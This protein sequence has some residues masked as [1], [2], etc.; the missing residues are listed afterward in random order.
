MSL[1]DW[2]RSASS[3]SRP[4]APVAV[5]YYPAVTQPPTLI[6]RSLPAPGVA[7]AYAAAQPSRLTGGWNTPTSSADT[8]I[9]SGL[10]NLRARSRALVRDSAYAK[11]AQIIVVNNVIGSGMGLQAQ[12]QSSR[13]NLLDRAN[14]GIET[15]WDRWTCAEY[16]HTGGALHFSDFERALIG[17]VFEAGEVFVRMHM[18]SFG[19]SDIPFALELIESERVPH[20]FQ[21]VAVT[22]GEARLG[23]EVDKYYRPI[24]YW[25]R[26]RHPHD[27]QPG[28]MQTEQVRPVPANEIIH[29][30]LVERFPQTRGVPWLHAT[31]KKLNDMDGYS[32]AEI[33]AARAQAMHVTWEEGGSPLDP[34]DERQDDGTF[35][36]EIQPGMHYK[37]KPG[38]KFGFH[39]PTRPNTGL[40][41]FMRYMLR[42]V[43]SGT[44]YGIRYA[45]LSGDYAQANYSSERA[46]IL[47][48]RDGWRALQQWFIRNFRQRVHPMWLQ[49]AVFARAVDSIPVAEYMANKQKF[50]AVK[51]KPRGWSW[52]DPTSEVEAYKEAEK[53]GY[54]TKTRIIEATSDTDIEDVLQERRRE[55][56]AAEKQDLAFDTDPEAYAPK[57]EAAPVA[58]A[59][60]EPDDEAEDEETDDN[61]PEEQQRMRV[62]K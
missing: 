5:T 34:I 31:A 62:V 42:E 55:L 48:D 24:R 18:A 19:G 15:A 30:R 46:A 12:V 4:A 44:G 43:A 36:R 8:E 58:P 6:P 38:Q 14:E 25:I 54:I 40:D 20:E 21:S 17:E 60:E 59:A 45:A 52:I 33:V 22:T 27:I 32:D 53:A 16:C 41:S 9:R 10:T 61:S 57:P 47:D 51:Y 2:F 37:L 7:R 35:E 50:E 39:T 26:D 49:Q 29:L 1:L 11:R 13:N 23:I 3:P 28:G 56:D